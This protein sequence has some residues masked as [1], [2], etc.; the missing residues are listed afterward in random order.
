MTVLTYSCEKNEK[1]NTPYV[2]P[3]F[4]NPSVSIIKNNLEFPSGISDFSNDLKSDHNSKSI[5]NSIY[6]GVFIEGP[7]FKDF[8][9]N[10]GLQ[11]IQNPKISR[12]EINL[13]QMPTDLSPID[14]LTTNTISEI[15]VSKYPSDFDSF[16]YLGCHISYEIHDSIWRAARLLLDNCILNNNSILTS[17]NSSD[18]IFVTSPTGETKVF[19]TDLTLKGIT[20][21]VCNKKGE[22]Y[23]VQAPVLDQ[24]DPTKL[25]RPKRIISIKEGLISTEFNLPTA[26]NPEFLKYNDN[27]S[28][29]MG[30]P[31]LEQLKIIENSEAGKNRFGIDYYVADLLGN[32]IYKID[33]ER[34]ISILAR[35]L[36]YP[37]SIAVTS[38]GDLF[39]TSSPVFYTNPIYDHTNP[40]PLVSCRESL[41]TLNP[42][43]GASKL[44]CEFGTKNFFEYL[45]TRNTGI[46]VDY[47]NIECN[48]PLD[49]NVTNILYEYKDK[50]YF[51]ITNT[52]LGNIYLIGIDK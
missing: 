6:S 15:D 1:L 9:G 22:V 28:F 41:Y 33:N 8:H 46:H 12:F 48:L 44:I 42:E 45:Y 31:C 39:Y 16:Y 30:D 38:S 34:N 51:L 19:L 7:G 27:I 36:T 5:L 3:D 29:W 50:L 24:N 21:L 13:D 4:R 23:A 52:R 25:I 10:V 35:D 26:I 47:D 18:K 43:S 14:Y 20:D 32:V 17:S 11:L 2:F 49:L 37:T 40:F